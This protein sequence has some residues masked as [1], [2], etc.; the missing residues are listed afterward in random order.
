MTSQTKHYIELSDILSLCFTCKDCKMALSFPAF[1]NLKAKKL[2]QCPACNEPWLD[3]QN[4]A[5][6]SLSFETLHQALREFKMVMD[7]RGK[8]TKG[9]TLALEIKDDR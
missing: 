3:F 7:D 4:G 1:E 5:T 2:A 6:I 8:V 9:F